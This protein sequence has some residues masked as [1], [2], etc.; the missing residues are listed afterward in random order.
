MKRTHLLR[1]RLAKADL[2][3]DHFHVVRWFN[4]KLDKLRRDL[5]KKAEGSGK[6]VLKG[7]RSLLLE[8]PGSLKPHEDPAKDQRRRLREALALNEPLCKAYNVREEL[9]IVWTRK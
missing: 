8:N 7:L 5:Q 3:P 2:A 4:Q 9:R 1:E 6:K